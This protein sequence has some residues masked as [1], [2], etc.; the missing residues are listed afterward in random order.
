MLAFSGR[1]VPCVSPDLTH[2]Q[3]LGRTH[4]GLL[5]C[6]FEQVLLYLLP[7]LFL[8]PAVVCTAAAWDAQWCTACSSAVLLLA[9]TQLCGAGRT[10]PAAG[11]GG[12][13]VRP[14]CRHQVRVC[15]A[16]SRDSLLPA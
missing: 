2:S 12:A 15:C 7:H 16:L 1:S 14:A 10:D 11:D 9:L 13:A 4:G 3:D 6:D 8:L 5:S